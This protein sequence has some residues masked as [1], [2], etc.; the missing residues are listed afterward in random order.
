MRIQFEKKAT[1]EN[2]LVFFDENGELLVSKQW[3]KNNQE[4][5]QRLRFYIKLPEIKLKQKSVHVLFESKPTRILLACLGEKSEE[6]SLRSVGGIIGKKLTSMRL[7]EISILFPTVT[8]SPHPLFDELEILM[9]GILLG[10]YQ[11]SEFK[12][13]ISDNGEDENPKEM[14]LIRL[15]LKEDAQIKQKTN[16]A[17][18]FAESTNLVRDWGNKPGNHF[19]PT[20]FMEQCQI[21][22]KEANLKFSFIDENKMLSLKMGCFLGVTQ[23]SAEPGFIHILEYKTSQKK[24]ETLLLVGKG[25]TFDSGGISLKPAEKMNEMKHDM[26][27]GA[28]VLGAMRIIGLLKPQ[29]NVIGMIPASEN[30]PGGKAVKPG[31]VLTAFN[32]KT[33]EVQ[34]TDAEGRLILAD[35]LAYGTDKYKPDAV[36]DIAT[37]T[38]ACLVALGSY[39]AGMICDNETLKKQISEAAKDTGDPVWEMPGNKVY[40]KQIE[41]TISDLKNVGGREAGMITAGLFLKNF[42]NKIPWSHLDIAGIAWDAERIDYYPLKGATGVGTRLLASLALNWSGIKP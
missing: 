25:L 23:G 7:E 6:N 13:S 11:Y 15:V 16:Q 29:I 12:S 36:I 21:L 24:A 33:V 38:G 26:C 17:M 35:A 4:L 5:C 31:D 1:S 34:N 9:E 27:G 39:H 20:H 18:I 10:L 41:G 40:E 32:G 42:V 19:T 30:L 8:P 37:L 28:A 22:A 2:L 3:Q 14:K